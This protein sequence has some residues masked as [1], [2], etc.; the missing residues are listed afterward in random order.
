MD[1]VF[2]AGGYATAG[3]S[4]LLQI[5]DTFNVADFN[6]YITTAT[7]VAGFV[8]LVYKIIN[9]KQRTENDKLDNELKKRE[10]EEKNNEKLEGKLK[11]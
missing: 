11:Q 2:E 4:I 6:P 1:T 3:T 9:I 5:V 10:L 7:G 8:F